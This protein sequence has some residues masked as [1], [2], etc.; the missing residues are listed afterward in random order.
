MKLK[1]TQL[2]F[3]F[4]LVLVG[5]GLY[6]QDASSID[7]A[8]QHIRNNMDEWGL[9]S[10][11]IEDMTASNLYT[12]KRTGITRAYMLQRHQGIPV[13]NAITTVN[14][15]KDGKVFFIYEKWE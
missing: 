15:N 5:N 13:F 1:S 9:T 4:M 2:L 12:D 3:L 6:A 8:T 7:I 11:D 10:Q 14:I